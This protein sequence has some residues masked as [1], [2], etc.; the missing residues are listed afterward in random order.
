MTVLGAAGTYYASKHALP[1]RYI[2]LW[3]ALT[4]VGLG[5]MYLHSTLAFLVRRATSS[6]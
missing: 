2:W 3:V 6:Q 5:T 4:F 1:A